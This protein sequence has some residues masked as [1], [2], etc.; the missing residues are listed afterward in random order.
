[1]LKIL[2]CCLG[3]LLS[4]CT[5]ETLPFSFGTACKVE[6]IGWDDHLME[7]DRFVLYMWSPRKILNKQ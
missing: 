3:F 5:G 7:N 2:L 1:M 4:G 6:V